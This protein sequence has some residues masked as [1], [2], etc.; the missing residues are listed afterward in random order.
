MRLG[1]PPKCADAA[2]KNWFAPG[3]ETAHPCPEVFEVSRMDVARLVLSEPRTLWTVAISGVERARPWV[4]DYLG[5]VEGGTQAPLPDSMPTLS[6]VLDRLPLPLFA[7]LL[8]A[9]PLLIAVFLV[10]RPRELSLAPAFA[11]SFGALFP[12]LA[13]ATVVFGDGFAD[14]AKQFQLGMTVLLG[15]WLIFMA[16]LLSRGWASR[17]GPI[18]S[19]PQ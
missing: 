6:R 10:W 13:L 2:G 7:A 16:A 4:P 8:L 19:D 11:L 17:A 14:T 15:F 3:M 18:A 1:L 5:K 12:P 9:P